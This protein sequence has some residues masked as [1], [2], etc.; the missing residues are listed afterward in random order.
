M[1]ERIAIF[2]ACGQIILALQQN[3]KSIEKAKLAEIKSARKLILAFAREIVIACDLGKTAKCVPFI[4]SA[5]MDLHPEIKYSCD[6]KIVRDL[7][8]LAATLHN[9]EDGIERSSRERLLEVKIFCTYMKQEL[10]QL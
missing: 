7:M 6:E 2:D 10:S 1:P 9:L 5:M 8:D 4:K 3:G